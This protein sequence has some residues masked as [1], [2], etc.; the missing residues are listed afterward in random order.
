VSALQIKY[1]FLQVINLL[2]TFKSSVQAITMR[3]LV[4]FL[5]LVCTIQTLVKNAE[6]PPQ[7]L[8]LDWILVSLISLILS[9]TYNQDIEIIEL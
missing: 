6:Q 3:H 8:H 5:Q 1:R 4:V 2:L 9:S 7:H